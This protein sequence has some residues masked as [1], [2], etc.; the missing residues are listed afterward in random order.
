MAIEHHRP[1]P[2]SRGADGCRSVISLP[3]KLK[4]PN[5]TRMLRSSGQ[6]GHPRPPACQDAPGPAERRGV[7]R[8]DAVG[9]TA[10]SSRFD[11]GSRPLAGPN[12]RSGRFRQG[13]DR[14]DPGRTRRP[15]HPRRL[16]RRTHCCRAEPLR[17]GGVLTGLGWP[18]PSPQ[19]RARHSR[20]PASQPASQ[21]IEGHASLSG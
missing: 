20:Q 17:S 12:C 18:V 3:P 14:Q 6:Q 13:V 1:A 15:G 19:C 16:P 11:A 5:E 9:R 8:V 2:I 4:R 10:R 21:R 7:R